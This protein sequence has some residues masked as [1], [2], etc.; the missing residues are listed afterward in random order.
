MLNLIWN[1]FRTAPD[2]VPM[3]DGEAIKKKF[4]AMRWRVFASITIG[5]AFTTSSARAIRS[6]RNRFWHRESLRRLK[7][8][9]SVRYS[10]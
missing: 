8:G 1:F 2:A 3:T 7:S 5:Y 6:L 10:S 4:N 9:S